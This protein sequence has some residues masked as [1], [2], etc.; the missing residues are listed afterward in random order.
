MK[1][2]NFWKATRLLPL[3]EKID[4]VARSV[5]CADNNH[6]GSACRPAFESGHLANAHEYLR[7]ALESIE[8]ELQNL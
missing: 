3:R 8:L 1:K 7:K 4:D 6:H 5:Y 2:N